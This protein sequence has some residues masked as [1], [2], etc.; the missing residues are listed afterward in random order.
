MTDAPL[1]FPSGD[2][3]HDPFADEIGERLRAS[4]RSLPAAPAEQG[5]RVARAVLATTMHAPS[6][7][8]GGLRPRWW[9]GAAAAALL[10]AVVARPWR[11]DLSRRE[12]DSAFAAG[13]NALLPSGSTSEE[14]GGTVRFEFALPNGARK[15][16]LV[17]DF[18]GWD[19]RA[20]P[21]VQQHGN[22][23]WSA[24]IPLA[25][26]RHDYAFVVDGTRWVVDALAPQAPDAGYGPT[27]TVVV[28][29]E[30]LP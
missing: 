6:R 17:G 24:R 12:A 13:R 26:G 18:N 5:E 10:V 29:F 11:P 22:G 19:E 8:V 20:T 14:V 25:P 27:N 16:S 7:R 15:V 2:E 21:M 4:Y 9:W 30:A 1:P 28:D 3:G 23:S